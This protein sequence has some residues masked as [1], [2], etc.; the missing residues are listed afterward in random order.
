[1]ITVAVQ[2]AGSGRLRLMARFEDPDTGM[3]GD[4]IFDLRPGDSQW[5]IPYEKWKLF[6]GQKAVTLNEDGRLL[7]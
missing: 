1:M 4:G 3:L 7:I 6:A 5:D 2:D